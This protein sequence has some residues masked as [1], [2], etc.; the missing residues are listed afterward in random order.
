MSVAKG[1]VNQRD[2]SFTDRYQPPSITPSHLFDPA[3]FG[4]FV[5]MGRSSPVDLIERQR[6]RLSAHSSGMQGRDFM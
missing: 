2:C 5:R 3:S 4:G 6:L 1:N